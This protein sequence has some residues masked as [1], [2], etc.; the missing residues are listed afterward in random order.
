MPPSSPYISE[1]RLRTPYIQAV[2]ISRHKTVGYSAQPA[3]A[4]YQG[5]RGFSHRPCAPSRQ[6]T[7]T[8]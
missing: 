3:E 5:A 8:S 4:E 7:T 6:L 2:E 1:I